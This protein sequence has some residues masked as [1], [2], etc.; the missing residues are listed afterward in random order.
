MFSVPFEDLFG[1][2][3]RMP[4]PV[5]GPSSAPLTNN[6]NATNLTNQNAKKSDSVLIDSALLSSGIITPVSNFKTKVTVLNKPKHTRANT[7]NS[8]ESLNEAIDL[9]MARFDRASARFDV[10]SDLFSGNTPEANALEASGLNVKVLSDGRGLGSRGLSER[11]SDVA[12]MAAMMHSIGD[13]VDAVSAANARNVTSS[14]VNL[15]TRVN[16]VTRQSANPVRT[17]GLNS[18]N[19]VQTFLAGAV[20]ATDLTLKDPTKDECMSQGRELWCDPTSKWADTPGV[21][22]WCIR[23]CRAN[24]NNCDP[25]R[26]S[27]LCVNEAVFRQKFNRLPLE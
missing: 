8:L 20:Q 25:I 15:G 7:V 22:H 24:T 5:I 13:A 12:L 21:A 26:C 10:A 3:V 2:V 18:T 23:N 16:R 19:N 6:T 11:G 9:A 4:N 1:A 17:S 27:C 14:G